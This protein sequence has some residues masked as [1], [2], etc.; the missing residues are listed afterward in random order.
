[1]NHFYVKTKDGEASIPRRIFY[2]VCKVYRPYAKEVTATF[3]RLFISFALMI[4][5]FALII[6]FQ[7]FEEF[8]EVGETMLTIATATLPS[9]LGM[10]KSETH[11][12]L[13]DQRRESHLRTWLEKITTTRKVNLNLNK[14]TKRVVSTC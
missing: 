11:Q 10:L 7:I 4:I 8:S 13:S 2:D 1:M 12:E 9:V 14:P 5:I 3:T 6:K